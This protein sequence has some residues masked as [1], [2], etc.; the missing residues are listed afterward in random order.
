MTTFFPRAVHWRTG[1]W[2]KVPPTFASR[3]HTSRAHRGSVHIK[4]VV[5]KPAEKH[6]KSLLVPNSRNF[7]RIFAF[8]PGHLAVKISYGN[9]TSYKTLFHL[10]GCFGVQYRYYCIWMFTVVDMV[11]KTP[12]NFTE[13]LQS[14][15]KKNRSVRTTTFVTETRSHEDFADGSDMSSWG[16]CTDDCWMSGN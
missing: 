12:Q 1:T 13:R 15:L 3:Q 10:G 11:C 8:E 4:Y 14:K 6:F 2:S 9:F 7:L 16:F 5:W